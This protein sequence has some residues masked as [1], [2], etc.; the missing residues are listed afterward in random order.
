MSKVEGLQFSRPVF[1]W[2]SKDKLTELGQFKA[3]CNILFTGPLC[4][5]KDKQRAGLLINWL[6]RQ[7]TQ[8]IASST[9][10]TTDSPEEVFEAL[11]RVFRPESNQTLSRFKFR[12]MKQT[13]AQT[14]DAIHVTTQIVLARV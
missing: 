13:S 3:D 7:A 11:E 5:L 8:I 1:D 6:G 10:I 2:D 12:N 4:D 9:D 14:C